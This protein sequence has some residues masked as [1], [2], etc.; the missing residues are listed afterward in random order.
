MAESFREVLHHCKCHSIVGFIL[1]FT[2]PKKD[3][4][5]LL[6]DLL[7]ESN[8]DA[9]FVKCI[10][11]FALIDADCIGPQILINQ[12]RILNLLKSIVQVLSYRKIMSIQQN[13]VR[14]AG[15]T[16]GL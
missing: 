1:C 2:K 14:I 11:N 15:P 3:F 12:L 10:T 8:L 16:P 9:V 6:V 4:C 7:H 5:S 13:P